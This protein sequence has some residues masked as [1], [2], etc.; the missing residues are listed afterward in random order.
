MDMVLPFFFWPQRFPMDQN[1]PTDQLRSSSSEVQASWNVKAQQEAADCGRVGWSPRI[2]RMRFETFLS[3]HDLSNSS[4]L[5]VGCDPGYF[6][7]HPL[8]RA[9]D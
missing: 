5:D 4:V 6:L 1:Q 8:S 2:Q 9:S 7:H 3:T